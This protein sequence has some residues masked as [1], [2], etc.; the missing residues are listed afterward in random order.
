MVYTKI[1]ISK[2]LC[3]KLKSIGRKG[4][5]YEQ[6]IEKLIEEAGYASVTDKT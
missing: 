2:E 1:R 5:T 3:L 4:E 6:V